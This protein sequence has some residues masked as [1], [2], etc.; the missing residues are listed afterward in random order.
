MSTSP[1]RSSWS[2][3]HGTGAT[4][5]AAIVNEVALDRSYGRCQK[6]TDGIT[7]TSRLR[8]ELTKAKK[9]RSPMPLGFKPVHR[10]GLP[11]A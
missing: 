2:R 7:H 10:Y 4:F 9:T 5:P 8:Q 3:C 11:S 6:A 1:Q